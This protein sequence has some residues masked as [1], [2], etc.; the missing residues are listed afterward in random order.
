MELNDKLTN[1]FNETIYNWVAKNFGTQEAEDPS[2]SIEDLSAELS[3][4][5]LKK[6]RQKP[7]LKYEATLILRAGCDVPVMLND[8]EAKINEIGG[9]VISKEHNGV[10]AL[11]Y[12]IQGE[13]RGDWSS[14]EIE[15]E[16]PA[17]LSSWLNLQ[18]NVLRYLLIRKDERSK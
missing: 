1:F 17:L 9:R 10:R 18:G 3:S 8:I 12:E 5:L 14:W 16:E 11:A 13:K 4:K 15:I 7:L 2:W 6:V